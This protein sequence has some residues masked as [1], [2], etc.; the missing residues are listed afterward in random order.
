M[1]KKL[2]KTDVLYHYASLALIIVFMIFSLT[3]IAKRGLWYDELYSTVS[4]LSPSLKHMYQNWLVSDGHPFGYQVFLYFWLKIVPGNEFWVRFPSLVASL[5]TIIFINR[6]IKA[7]F[8]PLSAFI[9]LALA[10]CS[11]NFIYYAHTSRPYGILLMFSWLSL[12]QAYRLS[13]A[14]QM[15]RLPIRYLI[16]ITAIAYLHYFGL[17]FVFCQLSYI[18]LYRVYKKKISSQDLKIL[19]IL[20]L[21]HSLLYLPAYYHL[22]HLLNQSFGTWQSTSTFDFFTLL[23]FK[24]FLL[25]RDATF[26]FFGFLTV[27]FLWVFLTRHDVKSLNHHEKE[28][29]WFL[30][31]YL[32]WTLFTLL[33]VS[34]VYNLKEERYLIGFLPI[35]YLSFSSNLAKF[36]TQHKKSQYLSLTLLVSLPLFI[37]ANLKVYSNTGKQDWKKSV[38]YVKDIYDENDLV[39][40]MSA[41][42][43][44]SAHDY[45][46]AGKVDEYFYV[47]TLDFYKFYFNK[48]F[49]TMPN[50]QIYNAFSDKSVDDVASKDSRVFILAPHHLHLANN[51]LRVL[52]KGFE[53]HHEKMF[54]TNVYILTPIEKRLT[55]K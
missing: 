20:F 27:F 41:D 1:L 53:I 18:F 37:F 38:L 26:L 49:E 33:V 45:L 8:G 17:V 32:L 47:R 14:D 43:S 39:L 21:A 22:F 24:N 4:A 34:I 16:T 52:E 36:V 55:K 28:K 44:V 10:L 11:Y 13:S 19:V 2:A 40:I 23:F 50:I 29:Q 42:Q 46:K 3:E 6:K 15:H 31:G 35:I 12:T 7:E 5:I 51:D 48:Y 54:S 25:N 30:N 9:C